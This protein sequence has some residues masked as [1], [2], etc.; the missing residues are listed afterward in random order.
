M[1]REVIIGIILFLVIAILAVCTFFIIRS[2]NNNGILSTREPQEYIEPNVIPNLQEW[3]SKTGYYKILKDSRICIAPKDRSLLEIVANTF[4]D[5]LS[6]LTGYS[7]KIQYTAKPKEGDFYFTLD[8]ND[9]KIGTEGYI[10][11]VSKHVSIDAKSSE[12]IFYGTRTVLQIL[13]QDESNTYI[14]MGVA[15]D[16][17]KYSERGMM[18][19]VARKYYSHEFLENYIK[20]LAWYKMNQFFIHFTD[21]EAFRLESSTYPGLASDQHYSKAYIRELQELA[22]QYNVTIIPE[23][24]LAAH[25]RAITEFKPEIADPLWNIT[26][27]GSLDL[28]NDET[29]IF[30]DNLIKE[31]SELFNSPYIHIGGDEY[32]KWGTSAELKP[33]FN[34]S[35]HLKQKSESLGYKY[36]GD[37]YRNY[38]NDRNAMIK[39]LGKKTRVWE[40][41]QRVEGDVPVD[42]DITIDIWNADDI[43][44]LE[45]NGFKI[46][47]GFWQ[48]T[49]I[50]PGWDVCY[51]DWKWTYENWQL[52]NFSKIQSNK[53]EPENTN[54]I[55]SKLICWND[56]CSVYVKESSVDKRLIMPLK[57]LS[58]VT[59]GAPRRTSYDEFT[60]DAVKIGEYPGTGFDMIAN[61]NFNEGTGAKII[62]NSGY[63]NTGIISGADWTPSGKYESA[64]SFNGKNSF[65]DINVTNTSE[66]WTITCWVNKLDNINTTTKLFTS[67]NT[68]INLE[69]KRT[70][71]VGI[72]KNS[73]NYYFDYIVPIGEWV[74]LSFVGNSKGVFLF[75][76][77]EL[78]DNISEIISCPTDKIGDSKNPF[79]GD[80]DEVSIYKKALNNIAIQSTYKG[81]IAN[82]VFDDTITNQAKDSSGFGMDGYLWGPSRVSGIIKEGI[83]FNGS[84]S[85]II[86]FKDDLPGSWSVGAWVKRENK[87]NNP[88]ILLNSPEFSLN[89]A[90]KG[91]DSRVGFSIYGKK[92]YSFNYT[93]PES[94]WVHLVFIGTPANTSL[95]VNGSFVETI[96]VGI[97]CPMDRI[98]SSSNPLRGL[99]DEVIIYNRQLSNKEISDLYD[100]YSDIKI[101]NDGEKESFSGL[102]LKFDEVSG[103]IAKDELEN[104][105]GEIN[106]AQWTSEGKM[107]NAI[108]FNTSGDYIKLG[109]GEIFGD[110]T[111][112]AWIK[113]EDSPIS[114]SILLASTNSFIKLEQ[115]QL[116]R[117]VGITQRGVADYVFD[118]VAP[119]GK[120]VH[121]AF[122]GS[123]SGV[124]LYINGI[125]KDTLP[126]FI[127]CPLDTIGNNTS[128]TIKGTVDE[129]KVFSR[130]LSSSEIAGL[131]S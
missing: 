27:K 67:L 23:I 49:Y 32:P 82:W 91:S 105:D 122:V 46:N 22:A 68:S 112:A 74:H 60:A 76:N 75:V 126:N 64:L 84:N 96:D 102:Y 80:I 62:D 8:C 45:Q 52:W 92:D 111:V 7:L 81:I 24:E 79:K 26:P 110:W 18:L 89:L 55:G 39:S 83:F 115:F 12:G 94:E 129:L 53:P 114:S 131:V 58:E 43:K 101:I 99:V 72:T 124:S 56:F 85:S 86:F 113:R 87:G 97:K 5:E 123:A 128:H 42:N 121:L 118:Y 119:A 38:L 48:M 59:W 71:K 44:E 120:W 19:D 103:S 30:A 98:G 78:I 107:G 15:R 93:A 10:M 35:T 100:L 109:K 73:R 51:G 13:K 130:A 11:D 108:K 31:Y 77:G 28:S 36:A 17:P 2:K 16:Y 21:D 116:G 25:T 69:T 37:I 65:V 6:T 14:P 29:N 106:G 41:F 50:L 54:V 127:P 9:S 20:Q 3:T 47:N 1:K 57:V 90:Q 33:I 95:Y 125:L 40:W 88:S 66:E 70:N 104:N 4:K 61:Y 117:K 34:K 63:N